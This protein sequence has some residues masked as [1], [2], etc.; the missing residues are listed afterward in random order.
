[1][2]TRIRRLLSGLGLIF[3]MVL[4]PHGHAGGQGIDI[5]FVLDNSGSMKTTDRQRMRIQAAKM[6]IHLLDEHDRAALISFSGQAYAITGLLPLSKPGNEQKLLRAID[7][8]NDKGAFTNIYQALEKARELLITNKTRGRKRHILLMSDGK[9][10]VG[11]SEQTLLLTERTLEAIAPRLARDRIKVHTLSFTKASN[12]PLMKLIAEDTRGEFTLLQTPDDI[13]R[14]FERIFQRAKK[15]NMLPVT[16]DS[17]VVD[18]AVKEIII[19]ATKYRPDSRIVLETPDGDEISAQNHRPTT[20]WFQARQ[21]DLITIR[22]PA[23]GYWLIKYSESGNKAYIVTDLKLMVD[24][25]SEVAANAPFLIQAWLEK[26]GKPV[27]KGPLVETT[28]FL[29]RLSGPGQRGS[30]RYSLEDTGLYGDEQAL[31]GYHSLE[32]KLD[33]PGE[34]RIDITAVGETF[35]R[36]KTVFVTVTEPEPDTDPFVLMDAPQPPPLPPRPPAPAEP[37]S[38][39]TPPAATPAAQPPEPRHQEEPKP[40][41][42]PSKPQEHSGAAAEETPPPASGEQPEPEQDSHWLS[43]LLIFLLINII[44]GAIAGAYFVIKKYRAGKKADDTPQDD[45]QE[46]AD[47]GNNKQE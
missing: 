7:Q 3:L 5:V 36:Q 33:K 39:A 40:L 26:S 12:I 19:L 42:L 18:Q 27:L 13:H 41:P 1:M 6:F 23:S 31:D 30:K 45:N 14:V 46:T 11:H 32:L 20:R 25:V 47:P 24:T 16:E 10:D 43:G 15:P 44:V 22:N 2:T 34:Y 28:G 35:D 8:I 21:F 17:F 4:S 38:P 37:A 29:M 9:M